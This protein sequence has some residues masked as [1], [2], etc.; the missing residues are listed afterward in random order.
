MSVSSSMAH[1]ILD[2]VNDKDCTKIHVPTVLTDSVNSI[3][4]YYNTSKICLIVS[5]YYFLVQAKSLPLVSFGLL[6]FEVVRR[7]ENFLFLRS[8]LQI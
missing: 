4:D 6:L 5:L 7:P 8:G 1:T 2:I 3:G